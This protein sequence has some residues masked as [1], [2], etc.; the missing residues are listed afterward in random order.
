MSTT[1]A[2]ADFTGSSWFSVGPRAASPPAPADQRRPARPA[3]R[4]RRIPEHEEIVDALADPSLP[5]R[6]KHS[7][8]AQARTKLKS[9]TSQ[10]V[11]R[12]LQ[13]LPTLG[14]ALFLC[15]P[16]A[17]FRSPIMDI[18]SSRMVIIAS[19]ARSPSST[20]CRLVPQGLK[21]N[22]P[23]TCGNTALMVGPERS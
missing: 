5:D 4:L 15:H 20:R 7:A 22:M 19:D 6:A 8:W 2:A 14:A 21:Q 12:Q 3:E 17:I 23:V 10:A 9:G 1:L 16:P 18:M 11:I 13:S